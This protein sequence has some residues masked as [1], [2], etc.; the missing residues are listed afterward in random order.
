MYNHPFVDGIFHKPSSYWVAP[1]METL[2]SCCNLWMVWWI[3]HGE[4]RLVQRFMGHA[5]FWVPRN[6]IQPSASV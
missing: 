4:E 6:I 2:R 1:F 5:D 3:A